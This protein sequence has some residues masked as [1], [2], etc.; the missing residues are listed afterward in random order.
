MSF[1]SLNNSYCISSI[2]LDQESL[3]SCFWALEVSWGLR[4]DE[5]KAGRE[6]GS[7]PG[8]LFLITT[9]PRWKV[10]LKK[11]QLQLPLIFRD[12]TTQMLRSSTIRQLI[13]RHPQM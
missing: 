4:A 7:S 2:Q 13:V 5:K 10:D 3:V 1:Q 8:G 11:P 9:R 12:N 6:G